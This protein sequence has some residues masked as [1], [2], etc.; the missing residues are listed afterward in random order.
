VTHN[1]LLRGGD[2]LDQMVDTEVRELRTQFMKHWRVIKRWEPAPCP[3]PKS[4][5]PIY[6]DQIRVVGEPWRRWF[7]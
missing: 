6:G 5:D 1:P 7:R 2:E 3:P 4:C